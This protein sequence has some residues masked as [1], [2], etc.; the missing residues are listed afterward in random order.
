MIADSQETFPVAHS[1][2]TAMTT[3]ASNITMNRDVPSVIS[4]GTEEASI[5][6]NKIEN[7]TETEKRIFER[8]RMREDE[9]SSPISDQSSSSDCATYHKMAMNQVCTY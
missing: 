6:T 3:T 2:R 9:R 8:K 5:S 7:Q 4:N 1:T